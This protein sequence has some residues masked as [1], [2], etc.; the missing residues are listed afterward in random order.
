MCSLRALSILLCTFVACAV[1]LD[2]CWNVTLP[3]RVSM[4][5]VARSNQS[6]YE[7]RSVFRVT[8]EGS[9]HISIS[10]IMDIRS[11]RM[12][13]SSLGSVLLSVNS[14]A[15]HSAAPLLCSPGT[16]QRYTWIFPSFVRKAA[17]APDVFVC[18]MCEPS[19]AMV[20]PSGFHS[21]GVW[22]LLSV[23]GAII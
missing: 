16:V 9:C 23:S 17:D 13:R 12:V 20:P 8:F 7:G 5:R 2:T 4:R 6:G 19:V 11:T 10:L 1:W 3:S 18:G 22:L 15:V 14:T 21:V